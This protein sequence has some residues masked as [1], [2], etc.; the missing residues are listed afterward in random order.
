MERPDK[1]VAV[2][3]LAQDMLRGWEMADEGQ[4][5]GAQMQEAGNKIANDAEARAV[6]AGIDEDVIYLAEQ[7]LEAKRDARAAVTQAPPPS[8]PRPTLVVANNN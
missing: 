8:T 4:R 6:A 7:L 2:T 3:S 5:I 1:I